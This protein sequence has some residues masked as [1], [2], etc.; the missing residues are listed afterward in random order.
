[1]EIGE[2]VTIEIATGPDPAAA[3][4]NAVK[5][6]TTA[7]QVLSVGVAHDDECPCTRT[8][9]PMPDCTCEIVELTLVRVA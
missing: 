8:D 4:A 1:L 9:R 7:R 5:P 3:V 6:Y 2:E